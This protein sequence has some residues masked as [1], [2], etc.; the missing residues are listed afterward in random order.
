MRCNQCRKAWVII[1][2]DNVVLSPYL[3]LF[4]NWFSRFL[5]AKPLY[6]TCASF[7]HLFIGN[8]TFL[9][10]ENARTKNQF[11]IYLAV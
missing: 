4:G 8:Q 6:K 11:N 9:T 1:T 2:F 10:I 3:I 5:I 7:D